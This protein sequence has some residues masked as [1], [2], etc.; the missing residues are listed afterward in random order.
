VGRQPRGATAA[1]RYGR[2]RATHALIARV[3][4]QPEQQPPEA[5]RVAALTAR[6]R[7]VLTLVATGLSNQ[8]IAEAL[9]LSPLTAKTHVSRIMAKLQAR[10]RAQLVIAAYESQLVRPQLPPQPILKG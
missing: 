1:A 10:D 9:V 4:R 2:H 6:E 5:G 3:V 8:E 7:E